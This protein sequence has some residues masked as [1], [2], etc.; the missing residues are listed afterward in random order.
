MIK[1]SKDLPCTRYIT[2]VP[3]M[4]RQV[5]S[6][7][8]TQTRRLIRPQPT[9]PFISFLERPHRSQN[10][11]LW[12][13]AWFGRG[14]GDHS[15]GEITSPFGKPGDLLAVKESAWIWCERR[16]NG[17]TSLGRQKWRFV[18]M[19]EAP[20]HYVADGRSR[21]TTSVVSPDSG[22]RWGWRFKAARFLPSWA[23]RTRLEVTNVRVQRLQDISNEDANAEGVPI[24]YGGFFGDAPDWALR[25]GEDDDCFYD[26]RTSKQNFALLWDSING[27]RSPWARNEWVWAVTFR[28]IKP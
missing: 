21:P 14:L 12:L 4:A 27:E 8:K 23:V 5:L 28:R 19:R 2:F 24:D 18:P 1:P 17:K 22:N 16:P 6:D 7:R 9:G 20:I 25:E 13:R 11:P 3:F 15:T 26:N 10:G